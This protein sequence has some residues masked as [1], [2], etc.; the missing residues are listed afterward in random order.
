MC[1]DEEDT[2]DNVIWS[3]ET[4][5]QLT[6]L[7]QTM[8]VKIRREW[9]LKPQAKHALKVHV[10]VTISRRGAHASACLIKVWTAHCMSAS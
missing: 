4:S 2:F 10:W 5:V 3:D 1:L 7:A 6:L 9:V 8:R